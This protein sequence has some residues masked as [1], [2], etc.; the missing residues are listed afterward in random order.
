M[1]IYEF[2]N[3]QNHKKEVKEPQLQV[4]TLKVMQWIKVMQ[5]FQFV[6]EWGFEVNGVWGIKG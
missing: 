6:C 1:G 5:W 3:E 4:S 2:S